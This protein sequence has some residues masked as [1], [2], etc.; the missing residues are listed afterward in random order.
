MTEEKKKRLYKI[1][2]LQTGEIRCFANIVR[3]LRFLG[4]EEKY[5]RNRYKDLPKVLIT[6]DGQKWKIYSF[7]G[8]SYEEWLENKETA[9]QR[10]IE[11]SIR[12]NIKRKSKR[13]CLSEYE[14]DV[15][16]AE[17]SVIEVAEKWGKTTQEVT[18]DFDRDYYRIYHTFHYDKE[19][20]ED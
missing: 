19:S 14:Y 20:E 11:S 18:A 7:C 4:L 2:S 12:S 1:Q 17:M 3:I 16:F 10:R 6:P 9:Q 8:M 15:F 5:P 13:E